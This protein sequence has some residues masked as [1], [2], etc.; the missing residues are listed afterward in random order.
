MRRYLTLYTDSTTHDDVFPI[1]APRRAGWRPG[2]Y[3]SHLPM[4]VKLDVR[5]EAVYTDYVTLRSVYGQGN[6]YEGVQQQGYTNKGFIFG[7]WIGREAKGG[8]AW[9]T[10]HL[11]ADEFLRIEY[12]RKKNAK[13]FIP[14]GTTQDQLKVE[15]S[16][17]FGH[18]LQADAWVQYEHWVA[19][20]YLLGSRNNVTAAVQV[21][22]C[23]K[24][25]RGQTF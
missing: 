5:A 10:Y 1:S 25:R 19:P 16:K 21:T 24:L 23:P 4:L 3:L 6:Y 14:G 8:Q 11:S 12:L 2:L 15:A 20:V 7:D 22:W 13:D 18:D 9:L 17:H